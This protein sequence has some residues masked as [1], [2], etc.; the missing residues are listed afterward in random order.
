MNSL[1][2]DTITA[3]LAGALVGFAIRALYRFRRH[4][5][6]LSDGEPAYTHRVP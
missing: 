1:P 4:N 2:I 3:F 6:P 5:R